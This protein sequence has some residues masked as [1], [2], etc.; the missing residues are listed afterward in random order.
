MKHSMSHGERHLAEPT[1]IA[2]SYTFDYIVIGVCIIGF[3]LLDKVHGFKQP[4][5]LTNINL[6]YPYALKD[7]VPAWAAGVIA[8]VVPLVICALWIVAE[9]KW[10]GRK[11]PRGSDTS[12]WWEVNAMILGLGLATAGTIVITGI[13][14][15]VTGRPRPD[16]IARCMP[17]AGSADAQPYG[18]VTAAIC[19]QTDNSIL[20]DGFKSFFSGHSSIC[21]GGL[22][23]L[24]LWIA[25]RVHVLDQRGEVW[26]TFIVLVPLLAASLVALSRIQDARHHP[27]DVIFGAIVG[28][29]VAWGSYRQ[30]YPSLASA[31]AGWAYPMR[32]WGSRPS[33]PAEVDPT[34]Y[35]LDRLGSPYQHPRGTSVEEAGVFNGANFASNTQYRPAPFAKSRRPEYSA[36]T[37]I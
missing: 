14:K 22:G 9:G 25:A 31:H 29:L 33:E 20:N 11:N 19:T 6:Q 34:N 17:R 8:V 15:N 36:Q 12:I 16:V 26:K 13:F 18:L 27:F 1:R 4:F 30:Y 7:R 3:L 10:R 23:Y 2:V 32:T 35:E 28:M 37:Q 5:A 21:F 24:S